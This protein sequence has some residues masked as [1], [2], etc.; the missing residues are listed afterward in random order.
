[1]QAR[2]LGEGIRV[3][4]QSATM[5]FEGDEIRRRRVRLGMTIEQLAQEADVNADTLGDYESGNRNPREITRQKVADALARLE[6]E[7]GVTAPPVDPGIVSFDV[8]GDDGFHITVKGPVADADV[9]R[10]QV[11]EILR[12]MRNRTS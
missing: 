8:T 9:L 6:E 2:R 7:T 5:S 10:R 12:E 1:M 4:Q 3:L 11:T